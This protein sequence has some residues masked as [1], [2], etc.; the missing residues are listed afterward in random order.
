MIKTFRAAGT[1]IEVI[2]PPDMSQAV[3]IDVVNPTPEEV[4]QVAEAVDVPSDDIMDSLDPDE[5][6]RFEFEDEYFLLMLRLPASQA[7]SA[8][9]YLTTPVGFFVRKERLVTVHSDMVDLITYFRG[10]RR[11]RIVESSFE[12]L[13]AI[14]GSTERR[15]SAMIRSIQRQLAEFRSTIL[16]SMRT[17]AVEDAFELNNQLIFLS[18]SVYGNLNS[19]RQMV[20]H[21]G[22]AFPNELTER[23]ED[24]EIDTRQHYEM[25]S[26]YRGLLTNTLDAYTSA[27]SNNLNLVLKIIASLS[28]ILMLPTLI[29]SLYGMNVG[30]PLQDTEYAFWVIV[31]ISIIWSGALWAVFRK[32]DWI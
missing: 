32:L 25:I 24:I 31:V 11:K 18:G 12:V 7:Q 9:P 21:R 30:L 14:L 17:E 26:M 27:I 8:E 15:F 5:R 29:A 28:L 4:R 23:L 20:H 3:W 2:H 22:V 13:V 19:I 6:P 16:K 10:R 1:D